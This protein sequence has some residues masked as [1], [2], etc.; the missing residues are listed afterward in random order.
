MQALRAADKAGDTAAARA[1]AAE[2]QKLNTAPPQEQQLTPWQLTKRMARAGAETAL[3]SMAGLGTQ[4]RGTLAG[5]KGA[6]DPNDTYMAARNRVYEQFEQAM[7]NSNISEEGR[8]MMGGMS[9]GMESTGIPAALEMIGTGIETVAGPEAR[10]AL[11]TVAML[12][13]ARSPA[14][15]KPTLPGELAVERARAAGYIVPP[16]TFT[17]VKPGGKPKYVGG[18]VERTAARMASTAA[19]EDAIS[20]KN[21]QV[22]SQWAAKAGELPE[23]F[24]TPGGV[25]RATA[26]ANAAYDAIK[27]FDPGP[28]QLPLPQYQQLF[29]RILKLGN[30]T[31]AFSG[32]PN[33]QIRELQR[34]LL[35]VNGARVADFVDKIR[36]LRDDSFANLRASENAGGAEL[37]RLGIAQRE[38][39]D[40]LEESL[41]HFLY[42]LAVQAP[43]DA[44]R[45]VLASLHGNWTKARARLSALHDIRDA[46]N[47]QTGAIDAAKIAKAGERHK[48]HPALQVIADAYEVN[49]KM[50]R[51][52]EQA[53]RSASAPLSAVDT[54]S[55]GFGATAGGAA[56][57]TTGGTLA[58]GVGAMIGAIAPLATRMVARSYALRG[59]TARN[60]QKYAGKVLRQASRA[61]T[62]EATL[63][64]DENE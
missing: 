16:G 32:A 6:L 48:L 63:P 61:I 37:R 55:I 60:T 2:L 10:D 44:E 17:G 58:G 7:A 47:E 42:D 20:M 4:M 40:I 54:I 8:A 18:P 50:V 30:N 35:N 27:A 23:G 34:T 46:M 22:T 15:V 56:G 45:A 9:Q 62:G 36:E 59:R 11:T 43:T 26:E 1:I 57:L 53:A 49:P 24:V 12:A 19:I 3:T 14:K 5:I 29:D 38:A 21:Q 51:A 33:A 28:V 13:T 39:A 64:D 41:D 52:P 25:Q 31:N